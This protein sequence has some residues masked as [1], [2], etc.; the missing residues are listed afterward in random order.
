[1]SASL[2]VV[3]H[4]PEIPPNTGNLMRLTV[5]TGNDLHLIEP[6]GFD[7]DDTRLR[8]AGLDYHEYADVSIHSSFDAFLDE[9]S[10]SRVFAFSQYATLRYTDVEYRHGDALLF[11]RESDGLPDE[12]LSHEAV[13][14]RLVIPIASGGRS[15][16]LA[17]AAAIAVYEAWRQ[18]DFD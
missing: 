15:L 11:G 18:H 5:N 10:P 12:V 7:L 14:D 17:N 13:T 3:L 16:N 1:M 4:R 9:V 8:R 2:H 6:L